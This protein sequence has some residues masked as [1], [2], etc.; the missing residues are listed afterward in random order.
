MRVNIEPAMNNDSSSYSLIP[1]WSRLRK[2][3]AALWKKKVLDGGFIAQIQNPVPV[4]DG[5]VRAEGFS[6]NDYLNP[7]KLLQM[8]QDRRSG[9]QWH[10]DLFLYEIPSYGPNVFIGF[11]GAK[12][13]FGNNTAWH[14]PAIS[15]LDEADKV[16]FEENNFYWKR[17]LEIVDYFIEKCKGRKQIGMSDFGGPADWIASVMGTENF[18]VE[19]I[20]QPDRMRDFA[21]R[22]ARES[23][24]AFDTVYAKIRRQNDG[25]VNWMPVW[26]EISLSTAQDDIAVNLSPDLYK[27]VFLPALKEMALQGKSCVLHWHDACRHHL[28]NLLEIKELEVIQYGHDPTTGDFKEHIGS[29]QKIQKAGKILFITCVEAKDVEFFVNNLDPRG[30][31]MIINTADAEGS[32]RMADRIP[33][34]TETRLGNIC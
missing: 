6:E 1:D 10:Y 15:S 29:M 26:N 24:K 17:T 14:E 25:V 31:A 33:R 21:L 27:K 7:E 34:L 32:K 22:L 23:R 8:K 11:C 5:I 28:D 30:L 12:V 19:S 2:R 18:L 20:Q 13:S 4:A 3:Y 16:H 9:W